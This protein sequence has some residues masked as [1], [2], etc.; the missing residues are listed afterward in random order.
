MVSFKEMEANVISVSLL[1][2]I[3]IKPKNFALGI[4]IFVSVRTAVPKKRGPDVRSFL[5]VSTAPAPKR[6]CF[7]YVDDE[8]AAQLAKGRQSKNT[9]TTVNVLDAWM[10]VRRKWC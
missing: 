3:E 2:N 1:A 8:K 10:K 7:S 6:S 5:P 9:T 4:L